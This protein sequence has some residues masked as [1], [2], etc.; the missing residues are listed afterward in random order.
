MKEEDS[1]EK[2]NFDII[3]DDDLNNVC[4]NTRNRISINRQLVYFY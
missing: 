4:I 2:K 1:K 3:N